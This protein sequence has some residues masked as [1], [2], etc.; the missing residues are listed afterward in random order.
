VWVAVF[1]AVTAENRTDMTRVLLLCDIERPLSNRFVRGL[2]RVIAA[3]Q[4]RPRLLKRS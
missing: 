1:F 2:N 3:R 4:P